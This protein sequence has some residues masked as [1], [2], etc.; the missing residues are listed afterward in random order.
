MRITLK[1]PGAY[2]DE[3]SISMK[4]DTNHAYVDKSSGEVPAENNGADDD[5]VN[6]WADFCCAQCAY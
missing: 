4:T 2:Y 3:N 5:A 6:A 1:N